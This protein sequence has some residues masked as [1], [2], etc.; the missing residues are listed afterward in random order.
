[1]L[2]LCSPVSISSKYKDNKYIA[3]DIFILPDAFVQ[4]YRYLY[5]QGE[6]R[7]GI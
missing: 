7:T 2:I 1:M 6:P 5:P 3:F 4:V